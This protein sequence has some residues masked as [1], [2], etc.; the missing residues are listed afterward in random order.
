[1]NA[2]SFLPKSFSTSKLDTYRERYSAPLKTKTST[3]ASQIAIRKLNLLEKTLETAFYSEAGS[4]SATKVTH[5]EGSEK[6]KFLKSE[7]DILSTARKL[8]N[9]LVEIVRLKKKEEKIGLV[10]KIGDEVKQ[11]SSASSSNDNKKDEDVGKAFD[12]L[13]PYL[14]DVKDPKNITHEEAL[15][16]YEACVN[17]LK[18]RCTA[19]VNIIQHRLNEENSKLSELQ[20]GCIDTSD[21][22]KDRHENMMNEIS[23]RIKILEQRLSESEKNSMEKL[24]A[25]DIRLREDER[26]KS[27]S[28]G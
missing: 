15:G 23:F 20:N 25:L 11:T 7:K 18:S 14:T 21:D 5:D 22:Q 12:Y 19:R 6:T 1:M 4:V 26:M 17:A 13:S 2:E 24:R 9:D 3:L 16:V 10:S 8:N 27:L 28:L